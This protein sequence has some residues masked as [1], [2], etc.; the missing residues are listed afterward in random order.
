MSAARSHPAIHP[1]EKRNCQKMYRQSSSPHV[2][3][4]T[5]T[6]SQSFPNQQP[7]VGS[8]RRCSWR[9]KYS[10]LENVPQ[11]HRKCAVRLGRPVYHPLK[12]CWHFLSA[13]L[14]GCSLYSA[15]MR[16]RVK[17]ARRSPALSHI[18]TIYHSLVSMT[19]TNFGCYPAYDLMALIS[20][21]SY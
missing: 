17:E 20:Q 2:D 19:T 12:K 14:R 4:W 3:W 11:S 18:L 13:P 6:L 16:G 21:D 9:E 5:Q 15:C 8:V 10:A 1:S 7:W